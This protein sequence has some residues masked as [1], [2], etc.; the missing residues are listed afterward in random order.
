MITK[1]EPPDKGHHT[2]W[3]KACTSAMS[4]SRRDSLDG[5]KTGVGWNFRL[6]TN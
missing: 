6:A 4:T 2:R 5:K 1:Q 3:A